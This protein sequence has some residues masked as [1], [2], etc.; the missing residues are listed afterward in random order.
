MADARIEIGHRM[1]EFF[2]DSFRDAKE[3]LWIMT[4]WLSTEY[5]DLLLERKAA[6]VD[7]RVTTSND[8]VPGQ[9][10]AI[11]RLLERH[12]RVTRP[13][14]KQLLT[15][16]T[17]LMI[18]GVVLALFTSGITLVIALVGLILFLR[19]KELRQ[20][21]WVSKLGE[22]NLRVLE[23]NPY[24]M[25][26]A[27]VYVA[28]DT[29]LLGSAN[30]TGNGTKHNVEAMAAIV[31]ADLAAHTREEILRVP[32]AQRFREVPYD[33]LGRGI[34]QAAIQNVHRRRRKH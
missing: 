16:G 30:L 34:A 32:E 6:G 18:G 3:R 5:A 24:R 7:V 1:G 17:W 23:S 33:V 8:F 12:E 27:K 20:P 26:H 28:D 31:D 10:E 14:N 11:N 15:W 4:P 25:V 9:R 2:L 29:V 22:G 19:G 13:E 21:Y